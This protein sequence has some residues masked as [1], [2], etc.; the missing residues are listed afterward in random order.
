MIFTQL[1]SRQIPDIIVQCFL[2]NALHFC[3]VRSVRKRTEGRLDLS[4]IGRTAI[5]LDGLETDHEA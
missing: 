4:R 2:L 5:S 3:L 1:R